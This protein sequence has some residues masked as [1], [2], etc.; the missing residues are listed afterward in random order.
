[1]ILN[2]MESHDRLLLLKKQS[3]YISEGCQ[4]CINSRP[5]E[6]TMPF[7]IFAHARTIESDE[8]IAIFNDDLYRSLTD[9]SYQRKYTA[10]SQ[11][12]S[13]RMIWA[14]RLTKPKAQE[15]SMLFKSY[16]GTDNIK[17]I[18]MIPKRELW[19]QYNKGNMTESQEIFESI[20]DFKNNR[21]KLEERESDDLSDIEVN[22]IYE[23]IK[24]GKKKYKFEMV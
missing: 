17:V 3:D 9:M 14:P 18:W 2:R 22:K 6:F 10:L 12:P 23:S 21:A 16:P 24:R 13:S 4:E 1:M 5:D 7:Y 8:K 15:N 11:V 20:N 19:S